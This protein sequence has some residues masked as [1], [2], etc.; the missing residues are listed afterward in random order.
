M[1]KALRFRCGQKRFR[2]L[3][4]IRRY[5]GHTGVLIKLPIVRVDYS[6]KGLVCWQVVQ[7]A[8]TV[9]RVVVEHF[10]IDVVVSGAQGGALLSS[11]VNL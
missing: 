6:S 11:H 4:K 2:V 10:T 3:A 9:Y 7:V 1:P 5:L 8:D